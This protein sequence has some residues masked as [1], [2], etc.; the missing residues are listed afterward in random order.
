[1]AQQSAVTVTK[2]IAELAPSWKPEYA[3]IANEMGMHV[4]GIG[5]RMYRQL[6]NHYQWYSQGRRILPPQEPHTNRKGNLSCES[7]DELGRKRYYNSQKA[8]QK[9]ASRDNRETYYSKGANGA[10]VVWQ[11][12]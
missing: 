5:G 2:N 1:M 10:V 8:A 4:F 11:R 3:P 12:A 9:A 7:T 6:P